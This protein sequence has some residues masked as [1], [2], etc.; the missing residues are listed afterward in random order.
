ML[1]VQRTSVVTLPIYEYLTGQ[2]LRLRQLEALCSA[3][4]DRKMLRC[5]IMTMEV[6]KSSQKTLLHCLAGNDP[7]EDDGRLCSSCRRVNLAAR[8]TILRHCNESQMRVRDET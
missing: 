6:I 8:T 7:T 4:Y 3:V 5:R 2:G 1:D